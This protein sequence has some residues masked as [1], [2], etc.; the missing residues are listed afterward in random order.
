MDTILFITDLHTPSNHCVSGRILAKLVAET[1]VRKVLC[2]GDLTEAFGGKASVD[3]TIADY[4]EQWVKTV[5]RVCAAGAD[6][7]VC[8]NAVYAAD[9]PGTAIQEIET[10]GNAAREKALSARAVG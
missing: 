9:D 5:E 8:G 1:G 2:G 4:R 10:L 3:R 6:V 7:I